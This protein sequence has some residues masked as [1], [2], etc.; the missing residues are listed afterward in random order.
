ML[1]T[2]QPLHAFDQSKLSGA[3]GARRARAVEKLTALDGAAR[4]LVPDDLV[5]T[6]DS[7]VVALAGVMGGAATEVDARTTAIVL[8]AACWEAASIGRTAR[9]HKLPS[10]ASKRFER[11]VDPGIAT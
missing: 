2:D 6:D 8:E 7:G 4:V 10:E 11:G 5:V 3:L 9:R 1:E